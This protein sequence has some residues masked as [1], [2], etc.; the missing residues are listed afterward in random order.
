MDSAYRLVADGDRLYSIP[1]GSGEDSGPVRAFDASDGRQL[2][3]RETPSDTDVAGAVA[4]STLCLTFE[5][6]LR[7]VDSETGE[8]LREVEQDFG[9]PDP[10]RVADD[11]I[12]AE[13]WEEL[14]RIS[15]EG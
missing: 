14:Y 7:L 2:W 8:L 9:F 10:P 11:A 4:G 15:A 13:G 1:F 12:I 5:N 3:S 6:A